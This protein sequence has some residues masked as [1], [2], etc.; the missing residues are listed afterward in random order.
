[1]PISNGDDD[2]TVMR[3]IDRTYRVFIQWRRCLTYSSG[4]T[5]VL[6]YFGASLDEIYWQ[7]MSDVHR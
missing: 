2:L 7:C 3:M 5:E 1:M 4:S 6:P